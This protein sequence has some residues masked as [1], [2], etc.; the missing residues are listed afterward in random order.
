M[1]HINKLIEHELVL[2]VNDYYCM[3]AFILHLKWWIYAAYMCRI[4]FHAKKTFCTN[5]SNHNESTY[6]FRAGFGC[7]VTCVW[8]FFRHISYNIFIDID[9]GDIL[10]Y[11]NK[12]EVNIPIELI[13]GGNLFKKKFYVEGCK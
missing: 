4:A 1:Y 9:M 13:E 2:I 12:S 6:F 8:R 3:C 5:N 11:L 10:E 7:L